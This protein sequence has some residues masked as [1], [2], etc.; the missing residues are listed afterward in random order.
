MPLMT[1]DHCV[2][3]DIAFLSIGSPSLLNFSID[4]NIG[5]FVTLNINSA[6]LTGLKIIKIK[7]T[8]LALAFLCLGVNRLL[9]FLL[10]KQ[11][12]IKIA[13]KFANIDQT[14]QILVLA[15]QLLEFIRPNY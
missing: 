3:H 7:W 6:N 5:V 2:L 9:L 8:K 4:P 13:Q 1:I 10:K 15:G 11:T 12:W 14:S